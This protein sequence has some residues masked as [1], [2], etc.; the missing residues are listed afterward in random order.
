MEKGEEIYR[1]LVE[2]EKRLWDTGEYFED[3]K[4]LLS[5]AMDFIE[6]HLQ[7]FKEFFKDK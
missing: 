4:T 2:L 1:N 5:D 6:N 7:E 3:D